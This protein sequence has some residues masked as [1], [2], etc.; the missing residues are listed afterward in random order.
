M[1]IILEATCLEHLFGGYNNNILMRMTISRQARVPACAAASLLLIVYRHIGFLD[2]QID[3][4]M[5][6][7]W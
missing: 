7:P 6:L 5:L 2:L 3:P 1:Y 4:S